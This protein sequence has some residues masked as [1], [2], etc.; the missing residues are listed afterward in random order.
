MKA[1]RGKRS[2]AFWPSIV[3]KKWLKVKPKVNDFSEDE[4]DTETES[5]DDGDLDKHELELDFKRY[6]EEFRSSS[7]EKLLSCHQLVSL[8]VSYV[9]DPKWLRIITTRT[10]C[11]QLLWSVFGELLLNTV[12][13]IMATMFSV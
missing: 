11:L 10:F 7:S 2:E 1:K 12:E 4:V 6:W 8:V 9:F 13:V 3:M 5:E